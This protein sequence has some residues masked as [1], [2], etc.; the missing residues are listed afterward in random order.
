MIKE[1]ES[2]FKINSKTRWLYWQTT[3]NIERE[4]MFKLIR[5]ILPIYKN[6]TTVLR[7]IYRLRL[8]LKKYEQKSPQNVGNI[9]FP[10]SEYVHYNWPLW[11]TT[12]YHS[13]HCSQQYFSTGWKQVMKE[14]SHTQCNT[15]GSPRGQLQ[16]FINRA[17]TQQRQY[18]R[19]TEKPT[20][21]IKKNNNDSTSTNAVNSRKITLVV[22]CWVCLLNSKKTGSQQKSKSIWEQKW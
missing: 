22:Q 5:L 21:S 16:R 14:K 1:I 15:S 8:F 6:Q 20:S 3:T 9:S 12:T 11:T 13:S 19:C 4:N 17:E 18:G 10:P 2:V 7:E